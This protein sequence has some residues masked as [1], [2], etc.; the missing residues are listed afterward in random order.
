MPEKAGD[1]EWHF[2]FLWQD[3]A[4]EMPC[5]RCLENITHEQNIIIPKERR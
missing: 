3:C 4:S 1:Y 5:G 2:L